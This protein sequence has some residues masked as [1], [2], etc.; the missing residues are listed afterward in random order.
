MNVPILPLHLGHLASF[1]ATTMPLAG[2]VITLT[3]LLVVMVATASARFW[4][5]C[6]ASEQ[7]QRRYLKMGVSAVFIIGFFVSLTYAFVSSAILL[8]AFFPALPLCSSGK[9]MESITSCVSATSSSGENFAHNMWNLLL[10]L[11][12]HGQI[13]GVFVLYV[14]EMDLAKITLPFPFARFSMCSRFSMMLHR[15]PLP[16]ETCLF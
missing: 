3:H 10:E 9:A 11:P 15:A 7:K 12:F 14:E 16:E 1:S 8:P 2:F 13:S 6:I 5:D 4:K